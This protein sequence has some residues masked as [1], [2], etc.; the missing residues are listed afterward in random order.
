MTKI[1]K[2]NL[3]IL[4]V[5]VVLAV[6]IT[7]LS[8]K[9]NPS[10]VPAAGSGSQQPAESQPQPVSIT[11]KD[12][13]EDNFTGTVPVISG[14]SVAA[15]AAENYVEQ[16]VSDFTQK[17]DQEVPAMKAQFGAG[18]PP[19][20]YSLDITAKDVK[21][22][23]TETVVISEYAYTGG[24][25]GMTTWRTFTAS[26][27]GRNLVSLSDV[28]APSEQAAFTELVKQKLLAW[29]PDGSTSPMTFPEDVNALSFD[30]F[31]NWSMDGE[32]LNIYF[33]KYDIGPGVLGAVTFPIPLSDL[34][35][36]LAAPYGSTGGN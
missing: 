33:D 9:G 17:A 31:S 21:G 4:A 10:P 23:D 25:N 3:I 29:I 6:V 20:T 34:S 2:R 8:S 11:T 22:P 35:N 5:L 14:I 19:A 24:A 12:I 32:N 16:E 30:S 28:I 18:T 26:A 27:D 13:K 7:L 1:T 15:T 36:M